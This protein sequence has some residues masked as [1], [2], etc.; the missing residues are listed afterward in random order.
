MTLYGI[1][2]APSVL[3]QIQAEF[4]VRVIVVIDGSKLNTQMQLSA[5]VKLL[6]TEQQLYNVFIVVCAYTTN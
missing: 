3:L 4:L 1:D 5:T 2:F 6:Q